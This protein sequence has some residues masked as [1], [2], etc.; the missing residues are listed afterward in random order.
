MDDFLDRLQLHLDLKSG[1][2]TETL[3]DTVLPARPQ[4]VEE[5]RP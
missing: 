2:L 1:Q 3:N 5:D 4:L